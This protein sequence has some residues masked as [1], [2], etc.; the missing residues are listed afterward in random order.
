M[1]QAKV[2]HQATSPL[3]THSRSN[4]EIGPTHCKVTLRISFCSDNCCNL[5]QKPQ[6]KFSS[7]VRSLRRVHFTLFAHCTVRSSHCSL[8]FTVHFTVH[9]T[10]L[11]FTSQNSSLH[12]V[13]SLNCS[14]H[15]VRSLHCSFLFIVH[16]TVRS[17][18]CS[19][20]F[21]VLLFLFFCSCS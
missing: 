15:T 2:F 9:F 4:N 10:S 16:C 18:H 13:R 20:L 21:I 3:L 7:T 8:Q 11:H 6:D 1:F 12:T 19:F 14:L 17:L 5:L